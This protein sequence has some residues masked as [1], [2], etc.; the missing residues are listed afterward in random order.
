MGTTA[1][2][3]D[4]VL[5]RPATGR[6]G[7]RTIGGADS[8]EVFGGGGGSHPGPLHKRGILP[9]Y[10]IIYVLE[11]EGEYR[12]DDGAPWAVGPGCVYHEFPG[13]LRDVRVAGHYT[14]CYLCLGPSLFAYLHA[15]GIIDPARPVL[16]AGLDLA[17]ARELVRYLD[18]L[19]GLREAA[20]PRH[21]ARGLELVTRLIARGGERTDPTAAIIDQA[22]GLLALRLDERV[23]LADLLA[24]IPLG[25][26]RLRKR[27]RERMGLSPG[28]YRIR[29][30]IERARELLT[31]HRE[32]L[33]GIAE[34]LGYDTP[35]AFSRQ[36]KQVVGMS[37]SAYRHQA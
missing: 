9:H 22:C 21:L 8:G 7:L 18:A 15:M 1:A 19:P 23:P 26:E 30:R 10:A 34:A 3:R 17:L 5:D 36:F 31:T 28:E 35:F 25:Y 14:E 4:L 11:G 13:R 20:L 37:P 6:G 27:F 16:D 24:P 29:R 33:T 2:F 32:P 12:L